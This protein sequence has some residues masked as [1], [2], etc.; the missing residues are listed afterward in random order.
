VQCASPLA[1]RSRRGGGVVA[2]ARTN[3]LLAC[4]N[5][6]RALDFTSKLTILAVAGRPDGFGA[7]TASDGLTSGMA[8][9]NSAFFERIGPRSVRGGAATARRG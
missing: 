9:N 8:V 7:D 5:N 2:L 6:F 1:T 3:K 4:A